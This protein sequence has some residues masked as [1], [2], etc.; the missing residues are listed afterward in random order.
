M[1]IENLHYGSEVVV[2]QGLDAVWSLKLEKI[3]KSINESLYCEM[4]ILERLSNFH[5]E[6][7]PIPSSMSGLIERLSK[8]PSVKKWV[9]RQILAGSI[10]TDAWRYLRSIL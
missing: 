4:D 10:Q 6:S 7:M 5:G 3:K 9:Y 8:Y 2:L 1:K